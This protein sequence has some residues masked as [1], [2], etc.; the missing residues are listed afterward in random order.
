M[1]LETITLLVGVGSLTTILMLC[2]R[3]LQ[4]VNLTNNQKDAIHAKDN[5]I[6]ALQEEN[7]ALF[8]RKEEDAEVCGLLKEVRRILSK[9]TTV[10]PSVDAVE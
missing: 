3:I 2:W 5:L 1:N 4:L 6:E 7:Q 8:E 10:Q 9:E